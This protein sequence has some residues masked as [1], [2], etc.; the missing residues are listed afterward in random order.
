MAAVT[1]GHTQVGKGLTSGHCL[2]AGLETGMHAPSIPRGNTAY[3]PRTTGPSAACT[4]QRTQ[5]FIKQLLQRILL[6]LQVV[7][8]AA[9]H[10]P[11]QPFWAMA[12]KPCTPGIPTLKTAGVLWAKLGSTE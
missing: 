6:G 2:L 10:V 3:R 8:A 9:A 1:R 4:R 12:M 7:I 11:L 5:A